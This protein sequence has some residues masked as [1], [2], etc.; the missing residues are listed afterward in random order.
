MLANKDILWTQPNTVAIFQIMCGNFWRRTFRAGKAHGE[1]RR[2]IIGNSSTPY[3][4][5]YEQARRGGIYAIVW[6]LEEH[7]SAFLPLARQGN[8]GVIAGAPDG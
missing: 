3:S 4:G 1:A 8:L 7:A 6:R 5:F 2:E